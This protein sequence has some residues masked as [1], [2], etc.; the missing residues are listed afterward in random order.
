MLKSQNREEELSPIL[1]ISAFIP[2]H[3]YGILCYKSR[4]SYMVGTMHVYCH[5]EKKS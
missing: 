3:L 2:I 1:W 5:K 4:K